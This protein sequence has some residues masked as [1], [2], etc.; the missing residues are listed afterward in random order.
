MRGTS[1]FQSQVSTHIQE[2]T[3]MQKVLQF[4]Q[5]LYQS[6]F[7]PSKKPGFLGGLKFQISKTMGDSTTTFSCHK[8]SV[9]NKM[10]RLNTLSLNSLV[11]NYFQTPISGIEN[12]K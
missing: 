5:F 12:T 9:Q 1:I 10:E 11:I 8:L 2:T 7:P 3:S 4:Y 6:E